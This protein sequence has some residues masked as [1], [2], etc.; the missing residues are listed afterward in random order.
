MILANVRQ[1]LTRGDAQLAMRLIARGSSTELDRLERVLR[2]EGIDTLLDDPG[3]RRAMLEQAQAAFELAS[4]RSRAC[5]V[6]LTFAG[7]AP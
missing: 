6:Q 7:D 1:C 4:D 5:K 3:L 2:E